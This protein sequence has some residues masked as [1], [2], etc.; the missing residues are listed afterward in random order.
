VKKLKTDED[1]PVEQKAEDEDPMDEN[2]E[3]K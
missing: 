2:E 3:E 1:Q